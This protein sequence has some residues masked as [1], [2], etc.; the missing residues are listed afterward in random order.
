VNLNDAL[1]DDASPGD[2]IIASSSSHVP[3]MTPFNYN[4]PLDGIIS[5]SVV[6][7]SKLLIIAAQK[8]ETMSH[9]KAARGTS[10]RPSTCPKSFTIMPMIF[11]E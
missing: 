3:D 9:E 11:V 4:N 8:E 1:A 7:L 2:D 10:A 6:G 5:R